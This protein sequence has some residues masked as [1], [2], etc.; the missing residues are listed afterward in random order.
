MALLPIVLL[1]FSSIATADVYKSVGPDGRAIYT[2]RPI[3][4]STRLEVSAPPVAPPPSKRDGATNDRGFV[5][6][7]SSFEIAS[8]LDNTTLRSERRDLQVSILLAPPLQ[9]S[10][11]LR[12]E[13]DGVGV[14]G[15]LGKGTQLRLEGLSLGSHRLQARIEDDTGVVIASTPLINVHVRPPLPEGSLP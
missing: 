3:E 12:I 8:P 7:Y 4:N 1:L 13:V 5:G 9:E 15:E 14:Q 2:D 6:P 10:H 11:L